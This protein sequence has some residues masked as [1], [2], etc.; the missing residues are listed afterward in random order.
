M[1]WGV[2]LGVGMEIIRNKLSILQTA[3]GIRYVCPG[4]TIMRER[5]LYILLNVSGFLPRYFW[6]EIEGL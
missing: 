5:Q 2:W 3:E 6:T 4:T 1:S